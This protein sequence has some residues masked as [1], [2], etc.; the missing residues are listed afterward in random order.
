M[1][2]ALPSLRT[3][4]R[5]VYSEYHHISEGELQFDGL[6]SHLTKHKAPFVVSISEDATRIISRVEYDRESNRMVG[7]ILSCDDTGMALVDSF[8][9]TTFET[10]EEC[11]KTQ[12]MSKLAYV[13]VAQCVLPG[14][15][16]FC[17]GCVG[18]NNVFTAT[19]V[20]KRWVYIHSQCQ[21]RSIRIISFGADGD[22]RLLRAM[23]ISCQFKIPPCEIPL[24]NSSPSFMNEGVDVPKEWT[25]FWLQKP[26]SLLYVQDYIHVAVKLKARLLK[27]S[28]VIPM[29]K[30]L[31]GSHHLHIVVDTY[32]KDQHGIRQKDLDHKDRQNFEAVT[33]LCSSSVLSLLEQI[34]DAKGTHQYLYIIK[35]FIDAFLNKQ[36]S[37]L[38]R[39]KKVWYN[40]FFLRYWNRWL[41]L[42]KA[43]NVKENFITS[44]AHTGIELNGHALILLLLLLR[45]KVP[46]GSKLFNPWLLGSQP[47]E[48][49][50]RAAR[51]M[52][53]TFSTIV[54]FSM[55]GLLQRLHRLHIQTTLESE[56][57][58]TGI[59]YP[60]I[61]THARKIG[62]SDMNTTSTINLQEISNKD[63]ADT[64]KLAKE[65]AISVIKEL[66]MSV[67]EGKWEEV[68]LKPVVPK[69]GENDDDDNDDDEDND[70]A[71]PVVEVTGEPNSDSS[72][73]GEEKLD[74]IE[75]MKSK[76]FIGDDV[77]ESLQGVKMKRMPSSTIPLYNA[78]MTDSKECSSNQQAK[79]SEYVQVTHNGKTVC[80]RKSTALWLFQE[81]ER[82]SGDRLFRVRLIQPNSSES[83]ANVCKNNLNADNLPVKHASVQVGDVCVFQK[84]D[85]TEWT[86]G[87]VL[88]FFYHA[89]KSNKAQQCKQSSLHVDS[90]KDSISVVCFLFQWHPPLSLQTYVLSADHSMPTASSFHLNEYA[91]TL[92]ENCFA[93]LQTEAVPAI[94]SVMMQNSLRIDLACA[95]YV[96]LTNESSQF[97]EDKLRN[98]VTILNESEDN[99]NECDSTTTPIWKKLGCYTLT[100]VHK[101]Q[102]HRGHLLNDIHIGAAQALL[103]TQFPNIGGFRNTLCQNSSSLKPF[104]SDS[105]LQA[106]HVRLGHVD[107]WITMSTVDCMEGEVE[108]FDSLQLSPTL[109]VQMTIA[110]YLRSQTKSI[111]IK[112][113]NVSIQSGSTDCGL[114]AIA[115]MTSI[116]HSED[117]AKLVYNQQELRIHLM[118]CFEKEFMEKFPVSKKRKLRNKRISKEI[119]CNIYC[120]CRLPD[121]EDGSKMIMCENCKEW[122]HEGCIDRAEDAINCDHDWICSNCS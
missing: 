13:Y 114:Y 120:S 38:Q 12:Q 102:L 90:N 58:E 110:K 65:E 6:A 119:V 10:I 78:K 91:F 51:S 31:A 117:P 54:N 68:K 16:P 4:Q 101:T 66:G 44:N 88:H 26:S 100:S 86:M 45:D 122:Y 63:I 34:P 118:Q 115:M 73:T 99:N 41:S 40:I 111:K 59:C 3:I 83:Q 8:L 106:I 92:S 85:R 113:V 23:K 109:E 108:L 94:P 67:K 82:V 96:T 69:D 50:F 18:I 1:P 43:F 11:F 98:V 35:N 80:I 33:H 76:G 116:A 25:W 9:A 55:Y 72:S 87:K 27:P 53:S 7:F 52:T 24:Y 75:N 121:Y 17:L 103:A 61:L 48:Q 29:G 36:I 20:L 15:P 71:I 97:L 39:I 32:S 49:T 14:I 81:Y 47:C 42:Q 28:V 112:V 60:R 79:H 5:Q 77:V 56:A 22:S 64:I 21:N 104:E 74:D 93:I 84:K 105:T 19:D 57:E 46:D 70:D 89:G 2:T 107:H 62:F 30:Y 37:P 95:K